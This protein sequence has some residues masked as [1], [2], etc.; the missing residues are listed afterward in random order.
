[1]KSTDSPLRLLCFGAGAIGTYIG[2]SLI[3]A[4]H[5]VVFLER[6]QTADKFHRLRLN[7]QGETHTIPNPKIATHIEAALSHGPFDAAIFA[8]KSFDTDDALAGLAKY[9]GQL[10]PFVCLQNG[11]ENEEK[12]AALL[13][14]ENILPATVTSAIGKTQMGEIVLERFRGVGL[15]AEHPISN[16]LFKAFSEA[17][18]NPLLISDAAGMKWSK[19]LTNLIGNATSAILGIPPGKVFEHPGIYSVEMLQLR[20]A[21]AVMKALKI[22]VINL[23]G[24]PVV[25]LSSV[26]RSLPNWVSRPLLKKAIGS[27]R[28]EK[29]PSFYIDLHSG[30]G[31]SE[32]GYLNGAV[33]RAGSKVGIRTPVNAF[34]TETLLKMVNGDIPL[35]RYQND[36]DALL[37]DFDSQSP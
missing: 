3:L 4:G 29:M 13:G 23:P 26:I 2:G 34:L 22:Q 36:P 7:L 11:V 25:L 28:G 15:Y 19:M 30:R 16:L 5:E 32:V 24:T 18:L 6:P 35:D 21:L 8:L 20:E 17:N 14:N 1:M 27:G 12:I 9:T 37:M 33:V 10:P 31:R